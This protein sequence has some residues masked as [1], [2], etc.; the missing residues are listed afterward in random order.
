MAEDNT[1]T[2]QRPQDGSVTIHNAIAESDSM[3]VWMCPI[4][5]ERSLPSNL[6]EQRRAAILAGRMK[7]WYDTERD[8]V[9][10]YTPN[11]TS[12]RE[13]MQ[14]VWREIVAKRGIA[15][16]FGK[17]RYDELCLDVFYAMGRSEQI[18][19]YMTAFYKLPPSTMERVFGRPVP[20]NYA[21]LTAAQRE[22]YFESGAVKACIGER[23]IVSRAERGEFY[24]YSIWEAIRA[25]FRDLFRRWGIDCPPT[26]NDIKMYLAAAC[27]QLK[28]DHSKG[29]ESY[30]NVVCCPT[31]EREQQSEVIAES[32][33]E[34]VT[35]ENG[36]DDNLSTTP[37]QEQEAETPS[38]I[39]S[40]L[41]RDASQ[42]EIEEHVDEAAVD[43]ESRAEVS[44]DP[45]KILMIQYDDRFEVCVVD[46]PRAARA[47]GMDDNAT[48]LKFPNDRREEIV[49][50]LSMAG[51]H[52]QF[53]I[54][55]PTQQSEE[56]PDV[57]AA[58]TEEEEINESQGANRGR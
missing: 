3:G 7:A 31:D 2:S 30:K 21:D 50:R 44:D 9:Y 1:N 32:P 58:P 15:T 28:K 33:E 26:D 17:E 36:Q 48:N 35:T 8:A 12:E 38:L 43:G 5:N 29:E 40:S 16:A 11:I 10:V 53:M 13:A 23:Y 19:A 46:T 39:D 52:P 51:L 42:P 4:E 41:T 49:S 22:A 27:D 34:T 25:A 55:S 45:D 18:Q 54:I 24:N 47:L 37:E 6:S 56:T 14:E 20:T 57:V